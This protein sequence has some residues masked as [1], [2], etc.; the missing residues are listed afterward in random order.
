M[1]RFVR[2]ILG[3]SIARLRNCQ[4]GSMHYRRHHRM[5]TTARLLWASLP[6]AIALLLA[7]AGPANAAAALRPAVGCCWFGPFGS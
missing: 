5:T 1:I 3:A 2:R 6:L 4:E 7:L